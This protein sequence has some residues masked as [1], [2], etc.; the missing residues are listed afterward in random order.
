MP[1]CSH[2]TDSCWGRGGGGDPRV[3]DVTCCLLAQVLAGLHFLH[4]RCRIIH[5]DIKPENILLYG[6]DKSLQRLLPDMLDCS[7]RTDLRLKGPG[8]H[9]RVFFNKERDLRVYCQEGNREAAGTDILGKVPISCKGQYKTV[10]PA[11]AAERPLLSLLNTNI[12]L[13]GYKLLK[14]P[15]EMWS[16]R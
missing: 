4:K 14:A 8:E 11:Y 6:R 5:T 2:S 12:R 1:D 10:Q 7:Q 3:A 13:S 9:S 15:T 16:C